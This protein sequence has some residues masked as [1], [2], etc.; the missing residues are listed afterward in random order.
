MENLQIFLLQFREVKCLEEILLARH[1]HMRDRIVSLSHLHCWK[2]SWDSIPW[3]QSGEEEE[4]QR[5]Q[6]SGEINHFN[7]FSLS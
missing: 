7:L 5:M 6:L 1:S 4:N 2:N 3:I